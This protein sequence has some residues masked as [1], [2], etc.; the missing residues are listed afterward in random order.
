MLGTLGKSKVPSTRGT[1][2]SPQISAKSDRSAFWNYCRTAARAAAH[3]SRRLGLPCEIDAHF[4]DR[5]LVDHRWRCAVTGIQLTAPA[6]RAEFQRNP[7]G[8]SL[9][10]IHPAEGYVPGNLRIVCNILNMAINE[11]GMQNLLVLVRA[12]GPLATMA[13]S[14]AKPV[15]AEH[16]STHGENFM[17]TI[18]KSGL[19]DSDLP[20]L[21]WRWV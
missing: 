4:I 14:T 19:S 20:A 7:F 9:D 11:W 2:I 15:P 10:R 16:S 13:D 5:L 17:A 6:G 21:S 18:A 1:R 3:R 8:P 12:L